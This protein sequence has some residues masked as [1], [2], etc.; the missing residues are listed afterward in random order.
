VVPAIQVIASKVDRKGREETEGLVVVD[1][2]AKLRQREE[3]QRLLQQQ[4]QQR[5]EGGEGEGEAGGREGEQDAESS[6]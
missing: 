2:G 6:T 5:E 3:Q 1:F 4:Q